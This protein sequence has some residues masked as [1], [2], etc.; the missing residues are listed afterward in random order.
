MPDELTAYVKQR[1]GYDYAHHGRTGNPDTAFV[2]DD[3]V[4]R[5]CV[6]GPPEA[7]LDKLAALRD[8]GVDQFALY[9]MHDAKESVIDAYGAHVVPALR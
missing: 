4:D 7:H 8:L 2:P 5:F 6:L 9:A 1:Q 3:I